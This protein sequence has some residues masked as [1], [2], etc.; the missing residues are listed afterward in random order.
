M[1]GPLPEKVKA[2]DVP[3][4]EPETLRGVHRGLCR[5]RRDPEGSGGDAFAIQRPKRRKPALKDGT[6]AV[7]DRAA[8]EIIP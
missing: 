3:G 1:S 4:A 5:E 2:E 7:G 8:P 6:K